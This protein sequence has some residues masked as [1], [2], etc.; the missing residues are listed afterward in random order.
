MA[1]I[2]RIDVQVWTG[3]KNG[4]GTDGDVYVAVAGREFYVDSSA[5]DFE[6][7]S[8]RTYTL[9]TAA[10][11]RYAAYNDPRSPQLKTE[12]LAKYPVYIRFEPY[13]VGPDWN[14]ERIVI[15]V[16]PGPSQVVYDNLR[17]AGTPDLWLGQKY[18]KVLY[19]DRK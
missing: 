6:R 5:N 10:N 16:N 4:A 15:T 1:N 8:T 14:L 18:G 2:N 3:S 9:G 13:G 19:L 11:V 17:I 7:G 12:D